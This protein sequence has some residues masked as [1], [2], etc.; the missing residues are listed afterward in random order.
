[1]PIAWWSFAIVIH[2]SWIKRGMHNQLMWR[3]VVSLYIYS[4]V[5][6]HNQFSRCFSCI[7]L[8]QGIYSCLQYAL[9]CI[10]FIMVGNCWI[11]RVMHVFTTVLHMSWKER[12]MHTTLSF[13]W[14]EKNVQQ[15]F[16]FKSWKNQ[17]LWYGESILPTHSN[18]FIC[19][20]LII[21]TYYICWNIL[22]WI[23]IW[24]KNQHKLKQS[25]VE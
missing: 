18:V 7:Q 11:D 23:W 16:T 8:I 12:G 4:T 19:W 3:T 1:M 9:H 24:K 22:F 14:V 2:R 25:T 6:H 10:A 15:S 20:S 21:W 5:V 13:S 17:A